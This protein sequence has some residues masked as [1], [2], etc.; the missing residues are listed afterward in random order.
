MHYYKLL[1]ISMHL[2]F[3]ALRVRFIQGQF[4]GSEALEFVRVSLELVGGTSTNA[5]SVTINPSEESP[6]SAQGDDIQDMFN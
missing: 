6:L 1:S 4:T 3:L 5:F 2:Y